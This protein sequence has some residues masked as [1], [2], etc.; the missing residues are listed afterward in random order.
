MNGRYLLDTS[1]VVAF[2]RGDLAVSERVAEAE[3]VFINTIVLGE[4]YFG[5]RLSARAKENVAQVDS[6]AT[7]ARVIV[8]DR[9][10]ADRYAD[11]KLRLRAKGRP[12]PEND[13]WI[14]A[15]AQQHD[16]ILISRDGH[17][18]ELDELTL[19]TW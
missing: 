19:A 7:A 2:P 4:L 15:T 13:I 8:C 16:L 12:L 5:A 9:G 10:T 18:E 14:A 17:F 11:L 6:F 1:I 3:E